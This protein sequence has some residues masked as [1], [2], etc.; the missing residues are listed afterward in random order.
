MIMDSGRRSIRLLLAILAAVSWAGPSHAQAFLGAVLSVGDSAPDFAAV[1]LDGRTVRLSDHRG[2]WVLL[3][4]WA[5]WCGP[6][7]T[8]LPH[9]LEAHARFSKY[10]IEFLSV[11]LDDNRAQLSRFVQERKLPFRQIFSGKGWDDPVA[12]QY[13]VRAI[14]SVFLIHPDGWIHSKGLRRDKLLQRLASIFEP[15]SRSDSM[16]GSTEELTHAVSIDGDDLAVSA[17][18]HSLRLPGLAAMIKEDSPV[19]PFGGRW[20]YV[21]SP[22]HASYTLLAFDTGGLLKFSYQSS[23]ALAVFYDDLTEGD[24]LAQA[25][26]NLLWTAP[27]STHR[28]GP[29]VAEA[30]RTAGNADIGLVNAFCLRGNIPRGPIRRSLVDRVLVFPNRVVTLEMK[31]VDV[32]AALARGRDERWWLHAAGVSAEVKNVE[33]G[34][35]EFTATLADG[36]PIQSD[37]YY[38]VAVPDY[39]AE[40]GDGFWSFKNAR[41]RRTAGSIQDAFAT[42]LKSRA[43]V[44]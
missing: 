39:L 21:K 20:M 9:Q 12:L 29:M 8:E 2:K 34:I 10:P 33:L 18:G 11:S 41:R 1:D 7:L 4:F 13:G 35:P 22:G 23:L 16:F 30:V 26:E 43:A 5:T 19:S 24:V 25:T 31:G 17:E 42:Y 28:L 44:P 14:P 40:G 32:L 6:C 15:S 27:W 36:K 38:Q 37:K 3:D